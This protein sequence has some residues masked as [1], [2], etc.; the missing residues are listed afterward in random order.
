MRFAYGPAAPGAEFFAAEKSHQMFGD[1]W[2][3]AY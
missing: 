2:S 1:N 3:A